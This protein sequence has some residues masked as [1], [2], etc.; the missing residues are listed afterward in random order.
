MVLI[1][2]KVEEGGILSGRTIKITNMAWPL[3]FRVS[4]DPNCTKVM[5]ANGN[6]SLSGGNATFGFERQYKNKTPVQEFEVFTGETSTINIDD[7]LAYI[8]AYY[9]R[10]YI[11]E[12]W[13]SRQIKAGSRCTFYIE[14]KDGR[15]TINMDPTEV[16][17]QVKLHEIN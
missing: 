13:K 8:T 2:H 1:L 11:K 16:R 5:I 7:P 9:G 12:Y 4:S 14:T 6:A 10:G 3:K 15:S 17:R